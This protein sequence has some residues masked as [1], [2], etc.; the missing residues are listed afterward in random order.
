MFE[1]AH[2][3]VSNYDSLLIG[4]ESLDLIDGVTFDPGTSEYCQGE[5]A[6]A[7]LEA[8]DSW[9]FDYSGENCDF[10]INVANE[11]SVKSGEKDVM[12]LTTNFGSQFAVSGG[13]DGDKFT[14][15]YDTQHLEF[16]DAPDANN[17]SDRN[18]D[19]IY[20]VQVHSWDHNGAPYDDYQTIKV[21]V[22]SDF[23]ASPAL[24]MYLLN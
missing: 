24:I 11:V 14:V 18:G 9:T 2:L 23:A 17:P 6:R 3:C 7:S 10:Y 5:S 19:N 16:I 20:R 13:A 21:K 8:D 4:W 1:N 12:H 22:E 15:N